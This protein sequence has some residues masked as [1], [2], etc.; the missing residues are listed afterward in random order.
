MIVYTNWFIPARFDGFTFGPVAFIRP[1]RKGDA[2][3]VAHEST[4]VRQFWRSFGLAGFLYVLS[5]KK[6]LEYEVEAYREEL[7]ISPDKAEAFALALST[8]YGLSITKD[9]AFVRLLNG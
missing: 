8:K 7:K 5:K 2:G 1:R 3:I 9:E 4:H 6:R